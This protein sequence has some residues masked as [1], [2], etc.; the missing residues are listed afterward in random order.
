MKRGYWLGLL[1]HC[2]A[3]SNLVVANFEKLWR[4][5][6]N[7]M[8]SPKLR[9]FLW[10]LCKG[11]LASKAVLYNRFCVPSASY[12]RCGGTN[13][14]LLHALVD[15]PNTNPM[16]VQHAAFNTINDAPRTLTSEFILWV[17]VHT[18]SDDF[19]SI[20]ATLWAVWFFHNK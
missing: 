7:V 16:W 6:W 11:T 5:V 12:D 18:T 13:E 2:G 14:I 17:H 10:R 1:R 19:L 3:Y 4:I 8:G 20:C 9:H 15:C